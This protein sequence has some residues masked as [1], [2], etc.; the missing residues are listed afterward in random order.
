MEHGGFPVAERTAS[1]SAVAM[2][3]QPKNG[4]L[5]FQLRDLVIAVVDQ[6]L[7]AGELAVIAVSGGG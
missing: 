2:R 1:L 3:R 6:A 4:R 5:F 7:A